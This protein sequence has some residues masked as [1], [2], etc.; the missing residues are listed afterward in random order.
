[1]SAMSSLRICEKQL[2]EMQREK[3]VMSEESAKL[4]A[5]NSG[6][7]QKLENMHEAF[8]GKESAL[9]EQCRKLDSDLSMAASLSEKQNALTITLEAKVNLNI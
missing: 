2:Q 9:V 7:K 1:M 3:R 6:M 5:E 4:G 8:E